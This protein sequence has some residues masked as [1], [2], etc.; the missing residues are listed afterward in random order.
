MAG[1]ERNLVPKVQIKAVEKIYEGRNGKTVALNGVN[2]DI[3]DN[4]FICVVGPSGCGKSTLLNIIAGLHEASSGEVL[5][6]GV[7]V[8][9]TGVDRGVV[10]QQYAL[11]PWLTVKKNVMFGL[12]LKKELTEEQREEIAMKYIKIVG[13]EKF[14]DAYPKELSGGMKQR[15]AIARAYAV[16]PSLLLMDEPFGALDAQTR[17]QLQTELLK[18]W[19]EEKKTCFFITHDV[20]EAILLAT[21]VIVMSARPGRIKEIIDIDIPYPRGQESKM[22]PRFTELKNYIWNMVYK[23]YLEVQK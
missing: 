6:D 1:E 20:E 3:Y 21:K 22:L 2:L 4:E 17:T 15:V 12:K 8:E 11:F 23:E 10:F 13:L 18:T 16:N 9:G 14:V 19:E 7:K 5:V